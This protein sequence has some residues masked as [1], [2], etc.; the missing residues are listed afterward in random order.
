[1]RT[2][3]HHP[4]IDIA[5]NALRYGLMRARWDHEVIFDAEL[6]FA[7]LLTNAWRHAGTTSPLIFVTLLG[8]TLRVAVSDESDALPN[9]RTP[10]D[11]A[12][13]GRGL[14]LVDQLTHRWGIDPLRH[15]KT[16]WYEL[17]SAA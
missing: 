9:H 7:E 17:D 6:A 5:R 11:F 10:A 1:M 13:S 3:N 14:L 2:T 15:G 8:G 12:E 4:N 16:V